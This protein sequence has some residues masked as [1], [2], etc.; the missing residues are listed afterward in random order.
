[1]LDFS[2]VWKKE[3]TFD[4]LVAGLTVS[5][6][7]KLTDEMIDRQLQLIADCTDADVTFQ[8]VDPKANDTFASNQADVGIAWTLGH[9]I[10]HITASSEE[11][12]ALAAELARGVE[13]HGRSRSEI[14]WE[15]VTT[16]AQCRERLEESRRMRHASL[17]MWPAQ[18]YLDNRYEPW[19]N[20]GQFNAVGRFILGLGHDDS[21]LGQ[22]EDVVRQAKTARG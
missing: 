13:Y 7:R 2:R 19:P 21:H 16:L 12:A 11:S 18:P 9:V 6:L 3:M 14:P 1:M 8:P 10:V 4:E 15:S 20:A 5:D 17:D 22:I